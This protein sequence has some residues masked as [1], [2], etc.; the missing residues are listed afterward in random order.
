MANFDM[1]QRRMDYVRLKE[2][3]AKE[4]LFHLSKHKISPSGIV[5]VMEHTVLLG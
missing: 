5:M 3:L 4:M 2:L 1:R